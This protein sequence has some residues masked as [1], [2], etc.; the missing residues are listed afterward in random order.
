MIIQ[1]NETETYLN[2]KTIPIENEDHIIF[3]PKRK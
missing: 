2:R 1:V 3:I